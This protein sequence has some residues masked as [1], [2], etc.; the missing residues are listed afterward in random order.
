M[1]LNYLH[2]YTFQQFGS[3]NF[4]I[5]SPWVLLSGLSFLSLIAC[6]F[7]LFTKR[8]V[9]TQSMFIF[10]LTMVSI[11]EFTYFLGRSHV[12]NLG[13]IC[14]PA[15]ILGFYWIDRAWSLPD[16]IGAARK[17]AAFSGFLLA[18]IFVYFYWPNVYMRFTQT[19]LYNLP[20]IPS[21]QGRE[22]LKN[23]V[24]D[25]GAM[26]S[27]SPGVAQ[28]VA[29][30]EKYFPHDE[31]VPLIVPQD[32]YLE[33]LL[34]SR[35]SSLFPISDPEQDDLL[36]MVRPN[37]P[38]DISMLKVGDILL[39]GQDTKGG[40]EGPMLNAQANEAQLLDQIKLKFKFELVEKGPQA[41]F[42]V[43]LAGLK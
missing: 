8:D 10:G 22:M 30:I 4:P 11:T 17:S 40:F 25:L 9:S 21:Q 33:S 2:L 5:F 28:T 19:A 3:L 34:R 42:A 16:L 12:N 39:L 6:C 1:Y 36:N 37:K 15:I 23:Y 26:D 20:K 13:H 43:R 31:R 38:Y 27:G 7:G 14:P 35:R 32:M 18:S 41:V 29:M 24:H